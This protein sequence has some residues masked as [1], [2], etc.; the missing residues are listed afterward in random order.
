M[1]F[2]IC[3]QKQFGSFVIEYIP[4][5]VLTKIKEKSITN[6]IFRIRSDDFMMCGFYCIDFILIYDF[7]KNFVTL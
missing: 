3:W 2:I 1:S 7:K 5:E 4:Q 6:N